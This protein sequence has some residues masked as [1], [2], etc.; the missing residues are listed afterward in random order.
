MA[1][2]RV[3]SIRAVLAAFSAADADRVVGLMTEDVLLRPSAFISGRRE[4]RGHDEVRTGLE[5]LQRELIARQESVRV[6]PVRQFVDRADETK[7]LTLARVTIRRANGDEYGTEIA[8]LWTL[9]GDLISRLDAW[10]DHEEGL[11]R[12]EDPVEILD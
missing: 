12:L 2:T 7:V 10:L 1:P 3:D 4:Y 6:K 9:Q 8:Y 11:G 5:E